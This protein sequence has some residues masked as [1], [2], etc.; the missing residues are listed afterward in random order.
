MPLTQAGCW[1]WRSGAERGFL[2]HAGGVTGP[3]IENFVDDFE[4]LFVGLV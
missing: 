1:D 2:G 3:E 4:W